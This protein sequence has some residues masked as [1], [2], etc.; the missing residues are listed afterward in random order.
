MTELDISTLRKAVPARFSKAIDE[1]LVDAINAISSDP[2][3]AENIIGNFL[4]FTSVLESGRFTLQEYTNAVKYVSLLL[5]GHTKASAYSRTFPD[6]YSTLV[7]NGKDSKTISAYV[8][9]YDSTKLVVEIRK[10]TLVPTWLYNRSIYQKAI[11]TQAE[12]MNDTS[13]SAFVRSSAANSLLTHLA[14]PKEATQLNIA[15]GNT[16]QDNS[17]ITA[18][19]EALNN[20][21]TTQKEV[22][23]SG[24]KTAKQIAE[25][26]IIDGEYEE[27]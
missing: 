24:E 27:K 12:I 4:S 17:A 11:N 14:E 23:S 22:I 13:N 8:S 21:S 5:L 19:T 7:A 20:L 26:K 9:A 2:M 10:Q 15:I 25:S 16:G 1:N 3:E 6:R 18:L